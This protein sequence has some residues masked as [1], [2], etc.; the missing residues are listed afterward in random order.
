[1]KRE[2]EKG[3]EKDIFSSLF[4]RTEKQRLLR[5]P[6]GLLLPFVGLHKQSK[7]GA[8]FHWVGIVVVLA[9]AFAVLSPVE[10]GVKPKGT[11]QLDFLHYNYIEG[12]KQLTD[13]DQLAL[14]AGR[15]TVFSLAK[16]GGFVQTPACGSFEGVIYWNKGQDFCFLNVDGEL[17]TE[18][19]SHYKKYDKEAD[20]TISRQG[21]E[22]MGKTGKKIALGSGAQQYLLNSGFRVNVDYDFDEYFRLQDEAKKM[23]NECKQATQLQDC[24]D[25]IKLSYWKFGSCEA[26]LFAE[27]E[28]KVVFCI[29]SPGKYAVFEKGKFIPVEYKV[30]LDFGMK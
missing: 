28:R 23:V 4:I 20:F 24:L 1:M 26:E 7:K 9:L 10:F 27:Q 8:L 3:N 30:G 19:N 5:R 6:E 22:L 13:T 2:N 21:K 15:E 11:W 14:Q 18:F 25:K 12:E 16:K 29:K 17:N